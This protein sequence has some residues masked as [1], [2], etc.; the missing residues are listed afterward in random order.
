MLSASWYPPNP[1]S[2]D[3]ST[4]TLDISLLGRIATAS[5]FPYGITIPEVV[6]TAD[7]IVNNNKIASRRLIV[8]N[9]AGGEVQW[10]QVMISNTS[11]YPQ[12]FKL[13]LG[14]EKQFHPSLAGDIS[15]YLKVEIRLGDLYDRWVQAQYQGENVV[16]DGKNKSVIFRIIMSIFTP[17]HREG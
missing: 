10:H 4:N 17:I 2:Y 14:S 5:T 6:N 12:V 16:V 8:N 15:A 9:A 11:D 3:A 13:E 1:E 7:N